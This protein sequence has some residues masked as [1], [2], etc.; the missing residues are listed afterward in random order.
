MD[1]SYPWE[2]P[3]QMS[4]YQHHHCYMTYVDVC[5]QTRKMCRDQ[6][7]VT[8]LQPCTD[9]YPATIGDTYPVLDNNHPHQCVTPMSHP[10]ST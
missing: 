3:T 7:D 5:C 6:S 8:H 9:M 1:F 10:A 4:A 2:R